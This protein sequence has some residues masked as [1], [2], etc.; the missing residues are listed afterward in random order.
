MNRKE[1]NKTQSDTYN[2]DNIKLYML[3]LLS[4]IEI[5]ALQ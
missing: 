1:I 5:T 3:L 2:V 4:V